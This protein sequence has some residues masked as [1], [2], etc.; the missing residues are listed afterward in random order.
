MFKTIPIYPNYEVDEN[1]N[2]RGKRF[3]KELKPKLTGGYRSVG[4]YSGG[5]YKWHNVHRLCAMAWHGLPNDYQ[6]LDVAHNDG[7]RLNNHYSNLRWVTRTE[8]AQD[9]HLHGTARGAKQGEKHHY[10]VLTG[11]IV[12]Q[13]RARVESGE[14]FS[15]VYR[16]MNIKKLTAYDALTG[17]TWASINNYQPP[18]KIKAIKN[19]S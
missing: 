1:S 9:R 14:S 5:K 2:I 8:N 16:D 19:A 18:V 6:K 10:A 13:L 12:K 4:I 7:N 11:D 15:D 17:K 3:A